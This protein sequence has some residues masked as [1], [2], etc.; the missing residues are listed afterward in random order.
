MDDLKK[1]FVRIKNN[2]YFIDIMRGNF[3]E[4]YKM[5]LNKLENLYYL[6][7]LEKYLQDVT[8]FLE[9]V[10]RLEERILTN[11]KL[12]TK[13]LGAAVQSKVESVCSHFR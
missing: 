6:S 7:N 12:F 5:E 10:L 2:S 3:C 11:R 9:K 1:Q 4:K 8:E 13:N